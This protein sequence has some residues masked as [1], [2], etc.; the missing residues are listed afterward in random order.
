VLREAKNQARDKEH[1]AQKKKTA[2]RVA[3]LPS[4]GNPTLSFAA[5]YSLAIVITKNTQN[6]SRAWK[7]RNDGCRR[8]KGCHLKSA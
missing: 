8:K 7:C 6:Y 2:K 3:R 5:S 4:L 1:R